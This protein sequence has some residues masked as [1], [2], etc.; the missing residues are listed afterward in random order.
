MIRALNG[1][2]HEGE[3]VVE[4]SDGATVS[5]EIIQLSVGRTSAKALGE[6][7]LDKVGVAYDG[8]D[9][10][11]V[12][13]RLRLTEHV[14]A[15]GDPVGH[16]LS[17]HLGHYEG[18]MAVR[19]A[20]GDDVTVDF[21]ATPRVVYTDPEA[22]AVGLRLDQAQEKGYDAFEET[23]GFPKSE[24]YG[25]TSQMRRC[26]ISIGSAIAPS[27]LRSCSCSTNSSAS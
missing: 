22:A 26:C 15:I 18:E 4:L 11:T 3:H 6:L 12:D 17:T 16:E 1:D 8:A 7:G 5:G 21:S 24:L 10:I 27:R 20:L 14:Y 13:D 9:Q 2:L 23:T 19:I 25:L